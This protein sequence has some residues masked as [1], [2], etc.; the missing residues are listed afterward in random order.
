MDLASTK[1]YSC[2]RT[3]KSN[4]LE[5]GKLTHKNLIGCLPWVAAAGAR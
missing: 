4:S 3:E 2:K 1:R 5:H